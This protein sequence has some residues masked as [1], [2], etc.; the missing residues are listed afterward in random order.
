MGAKVKNRPR[1]CPQRSSYPEWYGYVSTFY[2]RNAVVKYALVK[3][4]EIALELTDEYL[5]ESESIL[6]VG[7]GPGFYFPA[8]AERSAAQVVDLDLELPH[9]KAVK[10][11]CLGE[12]ID[13][14]F[15]LIRGD[16]GHLPFKDETFDLLYCFSVFE[17]IPFLSDGLK[18]LGRVLKQSGVLLIGMPIETLMSKAGRKV[19]GVG[20]HRKGEVVNSHRDMGQALTDYFTI[21]K[22]RK[23]PGNIMPDF[24]SLY[25]LFL[26]RKK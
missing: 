15:Q 21:E 18:E 6:D 7:A 5:R 8:I 20:G 3:R 26:C 17:H 2:S 25:V 22:F 13:H 14:R 24:V 12:D 11:M 10:Q 9:L 16:V 1:F 19:L 23:V 4:L